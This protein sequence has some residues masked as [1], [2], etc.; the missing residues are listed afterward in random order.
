MALWLQGRNW[1]SDQGEGREEPSSIRENFSRI[2]QGC[3]FTPSGS[4]SDPSAPSLP[5]GSAVAYQSTAD[6]D[7]RLFMDDYGKRHKLQFKGIFP[8]VFTYTCFM[9]FLVPIWLM[10]HVGFE[11]NVRYW[12]G[13]WCQ[14]VCLLPFIFVIF[15]VKHARTRE[16]SKHSII[17]CFLIPA[18]LLFVTGDIIESIS[19]DKADQLSSTDCNTF[20]GKVQLEKAWISANEVWATCL[21]D[22]LATRPAEQNVTIQALKQLYRLQDCE[23]YESK[24]AWFKRDWDYLRYLEEKEHCAGWCTISQPIWAYTQPTDACSVVAADA[25]SRKVNSICSHVVVYSILIIIVS[26]LALMTLGP[27]IRARGGKW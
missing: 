4:S 16:L 6:A 12:A 26:C 15:H 1:G 25:L 7:T 2:V 11:H 3:G 20:L 23:E 27:Y 22:T 13:P 18:I 19:L 14:F 10:T 5:E 9:V 8:W 24:R 17:W 21:Q